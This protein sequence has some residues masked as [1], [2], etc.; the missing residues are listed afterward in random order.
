MEGKTILKDLVQGDVKIN[1]STIED[2]VILRKDNKPT[3][4]LSAAVDDYQMKITHVIRGDDHK[5]NAFKQIQIFESMGWKI[6]EYAHIPLIHSKEG[7]KLSKRDDASTVEDYKKIGILPAALRNYLLRLGWSY[8]DKEIF[9]EVESIEFFNLKNIGKSPSKL[10]FDRIKS[11]NE[12]YIKSTKDEIL[13]EK[14]INYSELY[15]EKIPNQFHAIIK[16]SLFFLKNKSKSLEDIFNNS[17]YIFSYELKEDQMKKIDKSKLSIIKNIYSL[18][19]KEKNI[20]KDYLKNIFD[21]IIETEK[22]NFKD[23]GQ[24]LRIILTGSEYG[25]AIY[26]I[27][28]SLGLDEFVN[29]LELFFAKM[30]KNIKN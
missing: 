24:P 14:L 21:R 4:N 3:Y 26:D 20:S 7:K 2:F 30:D 12:F 23:L 19:K 25:P 6:P 9:S 28:S 15:K 5:I 1:N 27:A 10:D 18:I 8:K 17:K 16:V 11:I 13:L 29:R 22:I